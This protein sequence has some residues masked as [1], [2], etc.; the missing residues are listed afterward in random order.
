[1]TTFDN[2]PSILTN[3]GY[4]TPEQFLNGSSQVADLYIY[5]AVLDGVLCKKK[6]VPKFEKKVTRADQMLAYMVFTESDLEGKVIYDLVTNGINWDTPKA[7]DL[8]FKVR[9]TSAEPE[10]YIEEITDVEEVFVDSDYI[11]NNSVVV[12][13]NAP[14]GMVI[15]GYLVKKST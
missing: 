12:L 14:L 1:M 2:T 11:Q 13:I 6:I 4:I 10:L 15:N 8:V 5:S 7:G 3:Y 9:V